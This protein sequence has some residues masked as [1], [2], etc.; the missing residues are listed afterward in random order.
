MEKWGQFF[1]CGQDKV[2]ETL[3]NKQ[4]SETSAPVRKRHAR[5]I[6]AAVQ[7]DFGLNGTGTLDFIDLEEH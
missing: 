6:G 4:C 2:Q 1:E 7:L 3:R 5:M